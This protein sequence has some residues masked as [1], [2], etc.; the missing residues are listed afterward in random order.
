MIKKILIG[1]ILLFAGEH[2]F[3]QFKSN[4]QSKKIAV[5]DTLT[6]DTLSILPNTLKVFHEQLVDSSTYK[7]DYPNALLI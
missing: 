5:A 4:F 6:L 1:F 2:S 3:A 7:I